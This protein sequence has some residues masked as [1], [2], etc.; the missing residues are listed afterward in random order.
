MPAKAFIYLTAFI[1]HLSI[2]FTAT[3]LSALDSAE[4]RKPVPAGFGYGLSADMA[5]E[6][7][8][9]AAR[10][11]AAERLALRLEKNSE[12]R[13][14]L[15]FKDEP[16]R[17]EAYAEALA[18]LSQVWFIKSGRAEAQVIDGSIMQGKRFS[19][20]DARGPQGILQLAYDW[21]YPNLTEVREAYVWLFGSAP[22]LENYK[23]GLQ[24]EKDLYDSYSMAAQEYLQSAG[25]SSDGLATARTS[26]KQL[27]AVQSYFELLPQLYA[28]NFAGVSAQTILA[29]LEEAS[30]LMPD[31]YLL[32]AEMGRL[33]AW[34]GQMDKA[35]ETVN[36]AIRVNPD[37]AQ[38][39][40]HRGALL[41]LLHK[42]SLALAD[43]SRA[44]RLSGG[45][46]EFYHD[47]AVVWRAMGDKEAMCEDLRASCLAGE[48][49]AHEW[50]VAGGEC[51]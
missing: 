11:Q 43:L 31:N 47:R 33:Y 27:Q 7:A 32:L 40:S 3:P 45:K 16:N 9:Y 23:L 36:A 42:H 6:A 35:I 1:L 26:L 34:L 38:S 28:D 50:A 41:L 49:Q 19:R 24:M 37:F 4:D 29:R 39:Y 2:I 15:V 8:F 20:T 46:A 5:M 13:R 18:V 48:C 44:I 30:V 51:D 17:E 12:L 10:T 21:I 14:M 22:M 25:A